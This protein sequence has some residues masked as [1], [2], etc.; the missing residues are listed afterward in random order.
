MGVDEGIL[1][2]CEKLGLY[3][4]SIDIDKKELS[5]GKEG[6][7]LDNNLNREEVDKI[8]NLLRGKRV[9]EGEIARLNIDNEE[10]L[11]VITAFKKKGHIFGIAEKIERI[12][13]AY[14][15]FKDIFLTDKL[16]GLFSSN[17]YNLL[18][19]EVRQEEIESKDRI[20]RLFIGRSDIKP[21]FFL[22]MMD[23]SML[24]EVNDI[25]GHGMGDLLLKRFGQE[26]RSIIRRTDLAFRIGGDEFLA[27]LRVTDIDKAL[28]IAER[29]GNRFYS[30]VEELGVETHNGLPETGLNMGLVEGKSTDKESLKKQIETADKLMYISKKR[31]KDQWDYKQEISIDKELEKRAKIVVTPFY[32]IAFLE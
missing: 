17:A 4:F 13:K 21:P 5:F 26:L 6:R 12:A 18:L 14:S 8:I 31:Y 29:I 2:V 20:I 11:F 24:K 23:I 30:L 10:K 1:R 25:Y 3:Y 27:L 22:V 7:I 15:V 16:T 32:S 9:L 28:R 19:E